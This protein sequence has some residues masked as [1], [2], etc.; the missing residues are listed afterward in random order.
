MYLYATIGVNL[1]VGEIKKFHKATIFFS[2]YEC[3]LKENNSNRSISQSLNVIVSY[4]QNT[5]QG[6]SY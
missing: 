1:T 2:K 4:K 3:L 6:T 5:I